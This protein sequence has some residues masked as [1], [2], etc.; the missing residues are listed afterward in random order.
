MIASCGG[1]LAYYFE[2]SPGGGTLVS[3]TWWHKGTATL[4]NIKKKHILS[5]SRQLQLYDSLVRNMCRKEKAAYPYQCAVNKRNHF[6]L[7]SVVTRRLVWHTAGFNDL[8]HSLRP[9]VAR[10]RHV[11][12]WYKSSGSNK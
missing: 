5:Y 12:R 10:K 3:R 4:R 11:S 2:A 9:V 1:T 7:V 8:N 6:V